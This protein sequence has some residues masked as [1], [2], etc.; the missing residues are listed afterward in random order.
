LLL[1]IASR[2]VFSG[3]LVHYS[4]QPVQ[5]GLLCELIKCYDLALEEAAREDLSKTLRDIMSSVT[6]DVGTD[7]ET[8]LDESVRAAA[9][10]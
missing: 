7:A 10:V 9:Q 4:S 6:V 3:V 5:F 1:L 8:L 2:K